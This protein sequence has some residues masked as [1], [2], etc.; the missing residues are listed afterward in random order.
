MMLDIS[1]GVEA[2]VMGY[3][4]SSVPSVHAGRCSWEAVHMIC[5]TLCLGQRRGD[6]LWA[7]TETFTCLGLSEAKRLCL[8]CTAWLNWCCCTSK[9]RRPHFVTLPL[10]SFYYFQF[11]LIFLSVLYVPSI[12]SFH[13]FLFV[14]AVDGGVIP[15]GFAIWNNFPD[16][17]SFW[18]STLSLA[19]MC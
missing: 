2:A 17:Y 14:S 12:L 8:F 6:V 5:Q 1:T 15:R 11:F 3:C 4:K 19:S 16:S 9:F 18:V 10:I 7:G 13:L